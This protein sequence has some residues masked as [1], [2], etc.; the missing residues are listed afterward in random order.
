MIF[1][2]LFT[3]L[4][5]LTILPVPAAN[6]SEE[7]FGRSSVWYPLAG[8]IL[9]LAA[10]SFFWLTRQFFPNST[11][12]VLTTIFWAVLTGGLHLDGFSDCCDGFFASVTTEKRL[13][14]MKDPC[15]GTFAVLG[16]VLLI[17]CKITCIADLSGE[18]DFL[19]FPLIASLGRLSI[20][21]IIRLPLANPNGMAASLKKNVPPYALWAGAA[22]PLLLAVSLGWAG[23]VLILTASLTVFA[24]SRLALA[25]IHGINGDVLGMSVELTEM[26]VLLAASF[27]AGNLLP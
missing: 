5:F 25:K 2:Q 14:I 21:A 6:W 18:N 26:V 24:V 20:L 10:A 12:A 9:G 17:C 11:A 27:L 23:L 15:H 16:L 7:E 22:A 13:Q 4:E 1:K 3:A 8:A 19:L